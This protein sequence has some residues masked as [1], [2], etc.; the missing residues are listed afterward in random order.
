MIEKLRDFVLYDRISSRARYYGILS[1]LILAISFAGLNGSLQDVDE[2]F[3]AFVAR[4]SLEQNSWLVQIKLDEPT[5]F[6]SPLMFWSTMLSFK[7][8]G[9]SDFAGKLPSALANIA[10]AFA[11]L[12]IGRLV[13]KSYKTALTGVLIYE[14]SI[15][16][17]ISS[18]QICTDV[19]YQLFLILSLLFFLKA[20][21]ENRLWFVLAGLCN[22]LVFLSKSALGLVVPAT[23]LL[24]ILLD[25]QWKLIPHLIVFFL[26]SLAVS[27]PVFVAA[28]LK[29]PEMFKRS[30]LEGYL[31]NAVSGEKSLNLL[32]ILFG[33]VYYFVLIIAMLLPFSGGLIFI[34]FRKREDRKPRDMIWNEKTKPLTVF[35][36]V[37]YIGF[38]VIRQRLPH[39]TLPMVPALALYIAHLYCSTGKAKGIYLS[40][41]IL[42]ALALT[43][44]SGF[45]LVQWSRFPAWR[46][47]AIGLIALYTI[48]ITVNVLFLLKSVS[49]RTGL[50]TIVGLFYALFTLFAAVT[51]PMDFN[52]D[53]RDFTRVYKYPAPLY[54]VRT[55]EIEETGKK[56]P[57]YWYTRKIPVGFRDFE[58]FAEARSR[59]E[60]GSFIIYYREDTERMTALL[61]SFEILQTGRIWNIGFYE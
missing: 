37:T 1:L 55:R 17:Y 31:L 9:F 22:G 7:L 50:F 3:F 10:T 53:L 12:S 38:S 59:I 57:L 16:V 18:H 34:F 21:G 42:A 20:L 44:F 24:Y 61:P 36:L 49:A 13:F 52:R 51:V 41:T 32:N 45:A 11:L 8:F 60:E 5:F 15:Q 27:M 46:D 4:D 58:T 28:Y 40:N 2:S 33:F 6:K 35:F 43:A 48:F 23:F 56:N 54:M 19:Y 25:R 14:C 39:Y 30:F 26:I 47:V 29:V